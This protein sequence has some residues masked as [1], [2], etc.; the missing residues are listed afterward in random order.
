MRQAIT[1]SATEIVIYADFFVH[2]DYSITKKEI[3]IDFFAEHYAGQTVV[4]KAYD[5]ENFDLSGFE[6]FLLFLKHTFNFSQLI[7][8]TH[9]DVTNPEFKHVA[10]R[11][12]IFLS[13]GRYISNDIDRATA[14]GKFVGTLLG[15]FNIVRLRLAYELDC[16]FA[17][18]SYIAFQPAASTIDHAFANMS[19]LY[20]KEITWAKTRAF[21]NEINS[22]HPM[23][24]IE[25][26]NTCA[27]YHTIW[28]KF[29]IEAVCE[30]DAYSNFW[31]TEKTARCLAT[32]KPFVLVAGSGA[33]D[34]LK[35]MGFHTFG[36]VI[37]ESYDKAN[38]PNK[39]IAGLIS[40]LK[41]LY[42]DNTDSRLREMNRIAELN[43][44]AYK[45]YT[46]K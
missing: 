28:N 34:K 45:E 10:L 26:T 24:M 11:L 6:N 25:W 32:G 43:I 18:D 2:K 22:P 5:G 39:R 41:E 31:F 15:R 3:L 8:E 13:T 46:N 27:S 35:E 38:T 9:D 33:L 37:D 42:N 30:T 14:S 17:D 20:E 36:S 29:K 12:G 19:A 16:A 44:A 40:S 1:V 23:G 21:E 7:V 4:V